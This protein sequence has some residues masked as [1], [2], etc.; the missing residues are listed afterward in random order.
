MDRPALA[1]PVQLS[2][3]CPACGYER[4]GLALHPKALEELL[5]CERCREPNEVLGHQ[6][7]G[8]PA[9]ACCSPV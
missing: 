1:T 8:G 5:R 2:V 9:C 6:T 3:R 4:S 7:P